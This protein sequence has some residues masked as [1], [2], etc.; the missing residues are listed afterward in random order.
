MLSKD[1]HAGEFVKSKTSGNKF[2]TQKS[3][4]QKQ[5]INTLAVK[6]AF[7]YELSDTCDKLT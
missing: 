5:N 3:I 1:S 4:W 2:Y 6:P 7:R